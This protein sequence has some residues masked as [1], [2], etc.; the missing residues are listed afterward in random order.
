MRDGR[1]EQVAPPSVIYREPQTAF[2]AGFIGSMNFVESDIRDGICT[3]P[4]FGFS[5][6]VANGPVML[7]M[8]PEALTVHPAS[9]AAGAIVHRVTDFG[10]HK[11]VDI[12]LADGTRLKAMVAPGDMIR[13]GMTV[14]P[15]CSGFFAFRDNALIH[16]SAGAQAAAIMQP[17]H[18]A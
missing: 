10:T 6:P 1:T 13:A 5:I 17:L 16:Q 3:H 8:R 7:A 4:L 11:I 15:S 12:D 9:G 14:A 2:V 18:T